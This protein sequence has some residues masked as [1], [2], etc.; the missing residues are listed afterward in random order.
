MVGQFSKPID[1]LVQGVRPYID[2]I[3]KLPISAIVFLG[4]TNLT[5]FFQ[6]ITMFLGV[7]GD[8]LS[9]VKFFGES[10]PHLY[11][12][13]LIPQGW[14]LGV[15]I[16][17]YILAPFILTRSIRT[18]SAFVFLSA[19]LRIGLIGYCFSGD[20]WSYRFFPNEISTFLLGSLAYK[21]YEIKKTGGAID[22]FSI[23]ALPTLLIFL[24][25]FNFLP[26]E[27]QTKKIIFILVLVFTIGNIFNVTKNSKMDNFMGM[28]SY[29]IYVSHLFVLGYLL[30]KLHLP[31]PDG[32]FINTL[33]AYV[34]VTVFSIALYFLI[35]KPADLFRHRFK[36]KVG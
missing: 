11:Q 2:N 20:P 25:G 21:F 24:I 6:D 22:D 3:E 35:D 13:L 12:L 4:L 17:F 30:P 34:L 7:N 8:S 29:P 36:S 18:I 9:F 31:S 26:T 1:N 19:I 28:L 27:Y 14:S 10:S 15:E 16:S 23:L 32:R 5:I 33:L